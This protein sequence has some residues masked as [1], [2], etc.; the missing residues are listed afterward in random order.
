MIRD[1]SKEELDPVATSNDTEVTLGGGTLLVL[2]AGL[3]TLCGACFGL[4][5]AVGHRKSTDQAVAAVMPEPRSKT[6]TAPTGLGVKP[7]ASAVVPAHPKSTTAEGSNDAENGTDPAWAAPAV[8]GTGSNQAQVKPAP[9]SQVRPA[10]G[11]TAGTG[12]REGTLKIQPA[13]AQAQGWMVQIAAISHAED[14]QVLVDA[15]RKRGYEVT[16]RRDL[17]DNMIHV[18]TGPFVN[19]NDANAMRQ[20]LLNDGY[21]AIVQ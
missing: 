1:F 6:A 18:Q 5:Y 3:L 2:A 17:G 21:N 7:G 13:T 12:E 10:L 11:G 4:G 20:K 16:A 15:L 8:T 19:R 9:E 14:A